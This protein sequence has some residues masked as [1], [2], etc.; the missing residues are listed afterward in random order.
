MQAFTVRQFGAGTAMRIVALGCIALLLFMAG[1]EA[2]HNHGNVDVARNSAPCVICV[3]AH[4]K[5][6]A[7][8]IHLL[9]VL[10]A[11][12]LIAVPP[13]TEGKS[14][15]SELRLFIRPPPTPTQQSIQG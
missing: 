2:V 5:A 13:E 9:P 12:E 14:A 11:V 4:A 6:P 15:I 3:T 1:A 7:I 8:T 10:R